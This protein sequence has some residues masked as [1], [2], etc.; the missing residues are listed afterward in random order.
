M[1]EQRNVSRVAAILIFG[2]TIAWAEDPLPRDNPQLGEA[3]AKHEDYS[4]PEGRVF[5]QEP[6]DCAF[7]DTAIVNHAFYDEAGHAQILMTSVP[8]DF[9]SYNLF[10][11]ILHVG[12]NGTWV[13]TA[14]PATADGW[15][16]INL[17]AD[18]KHL[19]ALM[20]NVPESAGWET[21]VVRSDD[22]GRT[23]H[24]GS[25]IRKCLYW[26][27]IDYVRIGDGGAVT[28]VE[29]FDENYGECD[30][31]GYYVHESADRGST[32]SERRYAPEL[33]SSSFFDVTESFLA[34]KSSPQPLNEFELA[35]FEACPT[36]R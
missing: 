28:A 22:Y 10:P 9:A 6:L 18:R 5:P 17:S 29:H 30:K 36:R 26:K 2:L 12:P 25:D 8:T 24:Y 35:G 13:R 1:S 33:D 20:E 32:W 27:S 34:M 4:Y 3:L 16:F 31:P 23:W 7:Y 14:I 21:R 19:F 15:R 11:N